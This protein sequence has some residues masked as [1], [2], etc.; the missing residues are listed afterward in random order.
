M[1]KIIRYFGLA[2][3]VFASVFNEVDATTKEEAQMVLDVISTN[4]IGDNL[5]EANLS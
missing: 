2:M 4:Q 1:K 3:V 5:Y